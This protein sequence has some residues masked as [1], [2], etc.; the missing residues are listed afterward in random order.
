MKT[1]V[2]IQH[3]IDYAVLLEKVFS[4]PRINAKE[5]QHFVE[6]FSPKD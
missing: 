1:D 5:T 3:K 6:L 4:F 2:K